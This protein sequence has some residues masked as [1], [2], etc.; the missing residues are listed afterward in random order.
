MGESEDVQ[1]SVNKVVI[2]SLKPKDLPL[3]ELSRSLCSIDGVHAV[4]IIVTEVDART[5][6]IKI[7]LE[8]SNIDYDAIP[9]VMERC[10][11]VIRS[12]DEINITKSARKR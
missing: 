10:G 4:N 3:V 5:E 12:I 7:T 11:A 2:D 9:K 1:I 8:G 6:T